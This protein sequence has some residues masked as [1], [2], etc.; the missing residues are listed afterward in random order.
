MKSITRFASLVAAG[1][2]GLAAAGAQAAPLALTYTASFE[3]LTNPVYGETS[4]TFSTTFYI[5]S[6]AEP[7]DVVLAGGQYGS[8]FYGYSLD[9]ITGFAATYGN[10]TFTDLVTSTLGS[11]GA[12][13]IYTDAP[14]SSGQ[15]VNFFLKAQDATGSLALG[16]LDCSSLC[17]FGQFAVA[18]EFANGVATATVTGSSVDVATP[19]PEAGTWLMMLAGLGLVGGVARRR[20]AVSA[21]A[22]AV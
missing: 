4:Y 15:A 8:N 21:P 2:L 17:T 3:N 20:R 16:S 9:A 7:V 5:D 13:A 22:A 11:G 1:L 19:V 6:T 10:H 12:A 18:R 14:L